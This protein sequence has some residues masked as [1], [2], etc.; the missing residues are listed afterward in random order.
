MCFFIIIPIVFLT[1][2]I[3]LYPY[4][5]IGTK[6]RNDIYNI[7]GYPLIGNL[8]DT[9]NIYITKLLYNFLIEHGPLT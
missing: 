9:Y 8:F 4:R 2:L 1:Y 5:S 3:I 6:S 7:K